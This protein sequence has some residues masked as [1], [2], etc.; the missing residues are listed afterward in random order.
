MSTTN[1]NIPAD[2]VTY[3]L[4]CLPEDIGVRGNAL[5]SGDDGEDRRAE[6][7]I[8]ADLE[9]GNEWAWC[10]VK[11]TAEWNGFEG[12]DYLGGCSYASEDDFKQ[13]GGYYDDMKQQALD[14]LYRTV[15]SAVERALPALA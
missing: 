10:C 8:I 11:V 5:A 4:E 6:D 3:T 12:K 9:A 13:P 14:D 2:E 7:A 1:I 15:R